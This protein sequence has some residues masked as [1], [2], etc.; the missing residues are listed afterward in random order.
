MVFK[1]AKQLQVY[2][3]LCPHNRDAL[4]VFIVQNFVLEMCNQDL[5]EK[6]ITDLF[7]QD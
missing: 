1:V 6:A 7:D 2:L 4:K 5:A 3:I